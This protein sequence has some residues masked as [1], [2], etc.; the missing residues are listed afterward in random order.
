MKVGVAHEAPDL[1][2]GTQNVAP[3]G[4]STQQSAMAIRQRLADVDLTR[5]IWWVHRTCPMLPQSGYAGSSGSRRYC[6]S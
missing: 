3:G 4:Y 2:G 1:S 5:P 6:M